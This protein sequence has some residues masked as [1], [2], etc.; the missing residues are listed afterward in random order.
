MSFAKTTAA[1]ARLHP[2]TTLGGYTAYD[3]TIEFYGRIKALITP[4]MRV[5]DFGAGRG[6][7]FEEDES[8]YRREMRLL[9]GHVTEV[10][11]CDIDEAVLKNNAVDRSVIVRAGESW[12]VPAG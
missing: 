1:I 11:G 3:G 2:E 9:R 8:Q 4:E 6:A 10:I 7:W 5:E 12:P